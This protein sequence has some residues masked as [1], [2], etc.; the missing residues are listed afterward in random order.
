MDTL[1]VH[2]F[3]REIE[4]MLKFEQ[5]I[6]FD[7]YHICFDFYFVTKFIFYLSLLPTD[8]EIMTAANLDTKQSWKISIKELNDNKAEINADTI[9]E[10][11]KKWEIESSGIAFTRNLELPKQIKTK[12]SNM[13]EDPIKQIIVLQLSLI[14]IIFSRLTKL[15]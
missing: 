4:K 1:L 2:G 5:I 12:I 14:L 9:K 8:T 11:G 15:K 10:D 6:P 13:V 7:I 3:V